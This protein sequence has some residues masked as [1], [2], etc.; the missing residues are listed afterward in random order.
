M[1]VDNGC[2][3]LLQ[4]WMPH[5]SSKGLI[6]VSLT[7]ELDFPLMVQAAKWPGREMKKWTA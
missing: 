3:C 7:K 2:P 1:L 5:G 6:N 4:P